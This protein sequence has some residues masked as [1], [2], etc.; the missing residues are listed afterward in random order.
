VVNAPNPLSLRVREL[1]DALDRAHPEAVVLFSIPP[2]VVL[3]CR[4]GAEAGLQIIV[5]VAFDDPDPEGPVFRLKP[6]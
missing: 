3:R 4:E 2:D 6:Q 5:N 1:R